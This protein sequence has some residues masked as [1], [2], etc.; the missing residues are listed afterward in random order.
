ME[1]IIESL[2]F[3]WNLILFF[4][5]QKKRFKMTT[6]QKNKEEEERKY[7]R[8]APQAPSPAGP[9]QAVRGL[10]ARPALKVSKGTARE[11]EKTVF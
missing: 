2:N 11:R 3:N 7:L 6:K 1:S 8:V 9:P 10:P 4:I 5:H